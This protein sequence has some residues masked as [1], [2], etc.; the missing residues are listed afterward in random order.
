MCSGAWD[1]ARIAA[2][3]THPNVVEVL[4]TGVHR[5]LPWI[6]MELIDGRSLAEL[7]GARPPPALIAWVLAGVAAGLHAAD[8]ERQAAV[9]A[10]DG[11]HPSRI[12]ESRCWMMSS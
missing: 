11:R 4:D 9:T 10:G 3:V 7:L 5:G 2:Q 6:A 1:E 8:F 12:S